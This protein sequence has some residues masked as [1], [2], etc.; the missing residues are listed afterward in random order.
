MQAIEFEAISHQ[1]SIRVPEQIPDG[2]KLRVLILMEE[3]VPAVKKP[4]RPSPKLLGSVKMHD[5]LIRPAV[6]E[7]DWD[8]L[9]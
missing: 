4:N 2:T 8:A 3:G 7:T 9:K 6:P 5:D 1:H